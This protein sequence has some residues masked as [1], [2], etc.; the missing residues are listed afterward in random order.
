[1]NANPEA[2]KRALAAL[3]LVPVEAKAALLGDMLEL[4]PESAQFHEQVGAA[5]ASSGL[6]LLLATGEMADT[7]VRGY[8]EAG[9]RRA[10]RVDAPVEMGLRA[11][12]ARF[13]PQG[14]LMLVKASHALRL[15]RLFEDLP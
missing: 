7:Y 11:L 2:T 8:E 15:D 5:A 4:G 13:L 6:D 14:G 9:G 12:L 10:E 1:M 3:R